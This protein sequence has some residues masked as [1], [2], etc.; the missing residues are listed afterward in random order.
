MATSGISS[1]SAAARA[2][3]AALAEARPVGAAGQAVGDLHPLHPG[4]VTDERRAGLA[5][6]RCGGAELLRLVKHVPKWTARLELALNHANQN[7]REP[8][9]QAFSKWPTRFIP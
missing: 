3:G 9:E 8:I 7:D 6:G 2:G 4:G 5:L 1:A